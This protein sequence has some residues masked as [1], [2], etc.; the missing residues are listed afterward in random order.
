MH[1]LYKKKKI[2]ESAKKITA[3]IAEISLVI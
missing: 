1:F 2:I 3:M